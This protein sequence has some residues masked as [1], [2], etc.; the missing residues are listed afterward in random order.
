VRLD[1]SLGDWIREGPTVLGVDALGADAKVLRV[2]ADTRTSKRMDVERLLRERIAKR[3]AER[4]IAVP[5][6]AP[7]VIRP[8][9]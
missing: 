7:P 9:A 4:G 1:P 2:V 8:P 5:V 3:F 6:T